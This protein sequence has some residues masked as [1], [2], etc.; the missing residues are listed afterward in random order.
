MKTRVQQITEYLAEARL[1]STGDMF[2]G[3]NKRW[4]DVTQEE[5]E[6]AYAIEKGRSLEA[7][8]DTLIGLGHQMSECEARGVVTDRAFYQKSWNNYWQ[9]REEQTGQRRN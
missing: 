2:D 5:F 9:M 4:P 7:I 3:L 8:Q 1:L 6:A